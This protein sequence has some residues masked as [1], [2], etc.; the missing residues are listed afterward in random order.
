M[1]SRAARTRQAVV[2]ALLALIGE[3]HLRPTARE[4]A[5][6]A[7]VSLRSVYVHFDDVEALFLAAAVRHFEQ[8]QEIRGDLVVEG[9]LAERLDAFVERRARSYDVDGNVRKAAQ[10]QAPFSPAIRDVLGAAGKLG[11]SQIDEVFAREL[12]KLAE[13]D[14]ATARS[15]IR[16]ASS[17]A[18]WDHLRERQG[19]G[20][21]RAR[22]VVRHMVLSAL[23]VTTDDISA[24]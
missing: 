5:E 6:R 8:M 15:A 10:L 23:K 14:A 21:D 3:G 9:T 13:D 16:V 18:T 19:L 11:S 17:G 12:E 20:A 7:E 2:D 4:V 24:D 1:S 22:A